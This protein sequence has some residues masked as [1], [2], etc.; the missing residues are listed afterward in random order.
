MNARNG[1]ILGLVLGVGMGLA[2]LFGPATLLP[3]AAAQIG[4]PRL[5]YIIDNGNNRYIK[6]MGNGRWA[7]Y[8]KGKLLRFHKEVGRTDKFVELFTDDPL[9]TASRL[10]NSG[11]VW[12]GPNDVQWRPGSTGGWKDPALFFP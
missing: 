1:R 8:N 3:K 12:R 7:E 6:D 4:D 9:P 2:C 10:F 11:I 5:L